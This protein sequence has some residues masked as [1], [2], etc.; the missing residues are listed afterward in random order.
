MFSPLLFSALQCRLHCDPG[1]VSHR[2]PVVTCAEGRYTPAKPSSFV[3]QPA[4]AL[5]FSH[6][7]EVEVL[8]KK[9]SMALAN[10][11]D[12]SGHGRTASLL[13]KQIILIGNDTLSGSEGNFISIQNPRDGLLAMKY[14]KETFPTRGS[15]FQHTALSS[16]N[17]LNLLGGR[18]KSRTRFEQ[19]T[20]MDISLKWEES[21]NAFV[22]KFF[23]ACSVQNDTDSF[24]VFG[25]AETLDNKSTSVRDHILHINT[26]SLMVKLVGTMKKPRMAFGCEFLNKSC[27]LLSGGYSDAANPLQSIAP[28]EIFSMAPSVASFDRT[29]SVFLPYLLAPEA[30]SLEDNSLDDGTG[31]LLLPMTDSLQRFQHSLIRMDEV[32]FAFGG[33]DKDNSSSAKVQVFNEATKSWENH[34]RNL[35]SQNTEELLV[36]PFP[37]SSLDCAFECQCGRSNSMGSTRIFDGSN[38]EVN[39]HYL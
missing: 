39:T 19:S 38:T 1:Y 30:L 23:S 31:S 35:T 2:T 29:E 34:D 8:S 32:V 12:F 10:S 22:P 7:G 15:P 17:Q 27:I 6:T 37:T 24:Y 25:G 28:D 26:T 13:D 20:W 36:V 3:C 33:L 9:C 16:E 5:V 21:Q 4:A 14:T 11:Q 18:Y